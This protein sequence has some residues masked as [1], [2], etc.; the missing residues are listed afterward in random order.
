MFYLC[1]FTIGLSAQTTLLVDAGAYRKICPGTST[2]IGG[3]PTA[4]GGSG[5]Y[6]YKWQP[7][8]SVS[9]STISNPIATPNTTTIYTVFVTD[10][11]SG[12]R[13]PDTSTVTI[14]MYPYYVNTGRDT[15]VKQGQ[16]ITLHGQVS[17]GDS[18]IW[19]APQSGSMY[20][21][22][23]LNPEYYSQAPGNDTVL[24]TAGF[25]HGCSLYDKLII[26]VLP[27]TELHFY[28]SFSPNGDG[29]ND[30]F[31]IGNL[32]LY[33]NNTLDV[34]NRYGQKVLTKTPYG[35]DWDGTYLGAELPCGTY[36]YILDAHDDKAGKYHG[37]VTIIR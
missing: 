25:Y 36:F 33:P 6:T 10:P 13:K 23:S 2:K 31:F 17:P 8:T 28:N 21:Q 26:K 22:S 37:E 34:Y 4:S 12:T 29:A 11:S 27:S 30:V 3:N 19:W 35:N 9:D 5:N 7:T 18:V 24:L 20:N 16:T 14:Y 1:W 32:N 15:T